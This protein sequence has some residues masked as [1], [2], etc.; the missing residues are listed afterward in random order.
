MM[1]LWMLHSATRSVGEAD[2]DNACNQ[3]HIGE[4]IQC[5]QTDQGLLEI[6]NDTDDA[7][8]HHAASCAQPQGGSA[9]P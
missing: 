8:S 5:S 4:D 6:H 3:C 1:R 7:E 2:L 9:G